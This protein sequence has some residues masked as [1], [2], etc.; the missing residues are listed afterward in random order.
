VLAPTPD[1]PGRWHRAARHAVLDLPVI[2]KRPRLHCASPPRIRQAANCPK[3]RNRDRYLK[4]GKLG[5]VG[6]ERSARTGG[7]GRSAAIPA[8][9]SQ[10]L[11]RQ[12]ACERGVEDASLGADCC[13]VYWEVAE[14]SP[15]VRPH[16]PIT[17]AWSARALF[18]LSTRAGALLFDVGVGRSAHG[19][20]GK[21]SQSSR[22]QRPNEFEGTRV[23]AQS[24]PHRAG[25]VVARTPR[26]GRTAVASNWK[27]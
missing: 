20:D 22:G 14:S 24:S 9:S 7:W 1:P 11:L 23:A 21:G 3:R 15:A 10:E 13:G 19:T 27:G 18:A 5:G 16:A 2:E 6:C 4:C 8:R 25:S 17:P 12:I 26:C